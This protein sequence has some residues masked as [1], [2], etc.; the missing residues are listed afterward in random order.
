MFE[1]IGRKI[2]ALKEDND[3]RL[4]D[5]E[6]KGYAPADRVEQVERI[7]AELTKD[8]KALRE[9]ANA[10]ETALAKA[11]FSGGGKAADKAK[12]EHRAAFEKWFRKGG[13]TSALRELEVKAE[14]STLSD[15]DGGYITAPP[16][17]EQTID[18]VATNVSA[19]R[20]ICTVRPINADQYTKL[21]NV[22][23]ASSGWVGEE[24]TRSGDTDTPELKEI[25]INC[26]EVYAEPITTQKMLDDSIIDI[27]AWLGDE[28]VI[29]FD[30]QEGTK[31]I[32]GN[33][34]KCPRGIAAYPMI[35]NSSYLWGKVGY[36]AG[37]HASLLNNADKITSL[38]HALKPK[39]RANGL[40]LMNDATCEKIRL[41]KD[42]DGNYIWRA[43]LEA[44]KPDVLL[45]KPIEYDDYMDDIG[46]NKYP[47]A[48]ADFKRAYMIID[49]MGIRILRDN[50]TVKGKVKFYTTK[51]VGGGITNYEAVK[52]LKIAAA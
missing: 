47:L 46:A 17:V 6:S 42:G 34:V 29:E 41:L 50:L 51:R 25:V 37:G 1:E 5:I 45:G 20:R 52:F 18:R 21:M 31:F 19:M 28:V 30:D 24:E 13:D 4:K 12:A 3:K 35:T 22:G 27:G 11:E 26:Q 2:E 33:G 44:G 49:R 48:F 39:Y 9:Q 36:I 15:P 40:W 32:S 38:Q 7:N 43:G 14:L 16:E 10:M 8:L 23:G